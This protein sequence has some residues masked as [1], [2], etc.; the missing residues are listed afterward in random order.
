MRAPAPL[1]SER[2]RRLETPFGWIPFR[3]LRSGLLGRLGSASQL[4]YLF[5]CLVA[6]RRGMSFYGDRRLK[7][8]LHLSTSTL[9]AA[10]AELLGLD[11]IAF[12]GRLYQVLSLPAGATVVSQPAPCLAPERRERG[13]SP[14]R[15]EAILGRLLAAGEA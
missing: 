1:I 2:V 15:L 7:E 6:D 9:E 5:L 14:E 8:L 4:L 3:I 13:G 12:D 10:R 11:L